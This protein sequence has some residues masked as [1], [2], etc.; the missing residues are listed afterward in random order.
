[1]QLEICPNFTIV[2][3]CS[4]LLTVI[5]CGVVGLIKAPTLGQVNLTAWIS[6]LT[7]LQNKLTARPRDK[8][9]DPQPIKALQCWN[10]NEVFCKVFPLLHIFFNI[11]TLLDSLG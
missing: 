8:A 1:M 3:P 6:I 2:G 9:P 5:N 7:R 4:I 11:T 10:L